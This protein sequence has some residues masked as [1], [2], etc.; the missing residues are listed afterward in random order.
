MQNSHSTR[1]CADP[2]ALGAMKRDGLGWGHD[3]DCGC[4]RDVARA[5]RPSRVARLFAAMRRRG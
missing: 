1:Y 3:L 5:T 4:F 2:E